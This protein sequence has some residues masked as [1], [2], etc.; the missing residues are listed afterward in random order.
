MLET[1]SLSSPET[2]WH[3]KTPPCQLTPYKRSKDIFKIAAD[4][5]CNPDAATHN[6]C[7]K[8]MGDGATDQQFN[9]NICH[10][11]CPREGISIF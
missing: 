8:D 10:L 2:T 5:P 11:F 6:R 9:S 4:K 1:M 3:E 7:L